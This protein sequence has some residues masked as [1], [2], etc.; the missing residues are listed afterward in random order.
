MTGYGQ[1]RSVTPH[2]IYAVGQHVALPLGGSLSQIVA[3]QQRPTAF[4]K[5]VRLPGFEFT[6][7]QG[8]FQKRQIWER[9]EEIS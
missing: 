4:A 3:H 6:A 9:H 1:Y 8:A 7:A 5:I 2:G